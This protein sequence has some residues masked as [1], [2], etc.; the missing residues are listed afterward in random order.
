MTLKPV[1]YTFHGLLAFI[2]IIGVGLVW[3]MLQALDGKANDLVRYARVDNWTTQQTESR[4]YQFLLTLSEH[5]AGNQTVSMDD[6]RQQLAGLVGTARLLNLDERSPMVMA[7]PGKQDLRADFAEA[8]DTIRALL[9]GQDE[10]RGNIVVL[11]EI[12]A[13][14]D[15][16]LT[17][18]QQLMV[19]LTHMRLELQKR[20]LANASRLIGINRYML[21]AIIAIGAMF[22]TL[23]TVEARASRKAES[24]AR[25]D[26]GRFQ[27]FAEIGSDWLWETDADLTL[28]FVSD[29]I[30]SFSGL[31]ASSYVGR[32]IAHLVARA[33]HQDGDPV[34]GEAIARQEP[35]RDLVLSIGSDSHF[36]KISGNPVCD[37]SGCFQGFRGVCADISREVKREGRIRF[38]AEHDTLTGLCNRS[39]LQSQLR[40]ILEG[41]RSNDRQGT[42]LMLDLDG[43]KEVNDTFGHD[44]GDA[45][46]V[47]VAERL[48]ADLRQADMI[49]RLGGDEFAIIHMTDNATNTDIAGLAN[50]LLASICR[51]LQVS[52]FEFVIGTSIGIACF[53]KDGTSVEDLMKAADL[54]LYAAKSAGGN[55]AVVYHPEMSKRL[56]R[57]RRLEQDLKRALDNGD[58]DLHVQP[59]VDLAD[60]RL[61][62][63]EALLR[64]HHPELGPISPDVFINV[65]EETGLILPLGR[66]VL[67]QACQAAKKWSSEIGKGLIAVNVS[68]AQFTHQNLVHEVADVLDQIGLDPRHLEL[69]ITEGLLIRDQELAIKTLTEL[70]AMGVR[71]AIDDFGT[72]FSSLSYLKRFKVHKVKIDKTFVQDL[73]HDQSDHSI[74]RAV[75]M[76]SQAFGFRTIAEGVETEAQ[77][78]RLIVLGCD[79]AQGYLFGRP[80]PIDTFLPNFSST[81]AS[82]DGIREL[83]MLELPQSTT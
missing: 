39:R 42:L 19:S 59:Q 14:L 8:L 66:W 41:D 38:L 57:K 33:D 9:E 7:L 81:D 62:G 11:S 67:E 76:M 68:P 69:E 82:V 12:K 29:D 4:S 78:D 64:W 58:L 55:E 47:K 20:D 72:G 51:P 43:F 46:L 36:L 30:Q 1:R 63:G 83:A 24:S 54:A 56:K 35:F 79:E 27:D 34:L 23:L 28:T 77:R 18:L 31:P 49:A 5:V 13:I 17:S 74:V 48:S 10:F 65:A 3:I 2:L 60:G 53:P 21:M 73:E 22:A 25:V 70:D 75:V 71:L 52:G 44:V 6:V 37:Q 40:A 26:R 50:R 32:P 80:E 15:P 16:W 45:L 61:I